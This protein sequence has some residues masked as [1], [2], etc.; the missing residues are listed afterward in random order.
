MMKLPLVPLLLQRLC[1][2]RFRV[3]SLLLT[4][5]L[6]K[7]ELHLAGSHL[8]R[9]L[10]PNPQQCLLRLHLHLF[11]LLHLQRLMLSQMLVRQANPNLPRPLQLHRSKIVPHLLHHHRR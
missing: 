9:L 2:Q 5:L 7:C 8:P 11:M 6:R 1:S 4:A 10:F 3:P